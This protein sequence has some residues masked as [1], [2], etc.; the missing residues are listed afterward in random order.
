MKNEATPRDTTPPKKTPKDAPGA[1]IR[2]PDGV[3]KIYTS[4]TNAH[5]I[6]MSLSGGIIDDHN[7]KLFHDNNEPESTWKIS[8]I[9]AHDAHIINNGKLSQLMLKVIGDSG[10]YASY[11]TSSQSRAYHWVFK[12]AGT[13]VVYIESK[14]SGD[15][16]D[17]E[18][19]NTADN[20]RILAG[21]YKGSAN[22]KFKL[23]KIGNL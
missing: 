15:V 16:L 17:V 6:D 13:N 19:S 9:S 8:Y 10:V 5:I 14:A 22:Q 1:A 7:V 12:S 23:V 21:P 4:L 11:D 18:D 20:T 2:I 3:Y